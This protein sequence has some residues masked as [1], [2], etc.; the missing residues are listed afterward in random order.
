MATLSEN[1]TTLINQITAVADKIRS[2]D[3]SS[4]DIKPSDMPAR[5]QSIYNTLAPVTPKD[6]NFF[7]WDGT[8]VYAYTAAEINALTEL[9]AL[10]AHEGVSG[11]EWNYTLAQ[12]QTLASLATPYPA[13][14]GAIYSAPDGYS[15]IIKINIPSDDTV[16]DF[17]IKWNEQNQRAVT[18]DWGDN[19]TETIAA[20]NSV[21]AT[22]IYS[23]SGEY[24][25]KL[26]PADSTVNVIFPPTDGTFIGANY[27]QKNYV[28]MVILGRCQQDATA[29][30]GG[31]WFSDLHNLEICSY[32]YNNS[33]ALPRYVF[34]NATALKALHIPSW[35]RSVGVNHVS[36]TN[37][38]VIT[39]PYNCTT[40]Q[41]EA[42]AS[43]PSLKYFTYPYL[44]TSLTNRTLAFSNVQRLILPPNITALASGAFQDVNCA[45]TELVLPQSLTTINASVFAVMPTGMYAMAIPYVLIPTGVTSIGGGAFQN[46]P[47]HVMDLRGRQT[48]P[49]LGNTN[50]VNKVDV[51]VVDDDAY[52]TAIAAT[53]WATYASKFV[54]ASDY[55]G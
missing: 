36:A 3:G 34:L 43:N 35:I 45:I 49:T 51:F 5:I 48:M 30:N 6:Y 53:N 14:V 39:V 41:Y 15:T 50:A 44:L 33:T 29:G 26:T 8:L 52:D 32:G 19:Q 11:K 38:S 23:A 17:Q 27:R 13:N 25:I 2:L 28:K 24:Y 54:K 21:T 9:P 18:V 31:R 12:L 20:A 4:T 16:R 10:P 22:H 42:F 40:I 55:N 47:I 37:V 1:V 7:D 46:R